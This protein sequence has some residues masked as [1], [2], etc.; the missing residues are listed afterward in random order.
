MERAVFSSSVHRFGKGAGLVSNGLHKVVL[1][2]ESGVG[3]ADFFV[4]KS[5][6]SGT[7]GDLIPLTEVEAVE[8]NYEA[9]VD[10]ATRQTFLANGSG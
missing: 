9:A 1:A 5:F 8:S 3:E 6:G 2:L 4:E 7:V 10:L